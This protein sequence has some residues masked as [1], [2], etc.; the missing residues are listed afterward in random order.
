L[1]ITRD[2][3]F[4]DSDAAKRPVQ[5]SKYKKNEL[6]VDILER[7]NCSIDPDGKTEYCEIVG[8]I[9]MR[10]FLT[11]KPIVRL[12]LNEDLIIGKSLI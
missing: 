7:I 8:S 12:G 6:F 10:S 1:N 11:G 3:T 2:K 4:I 5:T 9:I